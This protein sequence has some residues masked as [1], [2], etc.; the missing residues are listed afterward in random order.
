MHVCLKALV[1]RSGFIHFG[2]GFNAYSV[3]I[4]NSMCTAIYIANSAFCYR[5]SNILDKSILNK[6]VEFGCRKSMFGL[7]DLSFL[8]AKISI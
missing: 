8:L 7:C 2:D 1:V 3:V 4:H 5:E 6:N